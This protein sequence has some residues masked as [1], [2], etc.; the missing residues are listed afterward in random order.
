M[1]QA[2]DQ[3]KI[4]VITKEDREKFKRLDHYLDSNCPEI[5]RSLLKK[6]FTH[7]NAITGLLTTTPIKL[8]L[9]KMP[10][11]NTQVTIQIPE[12]KDSPLKAENIPLEI[13]FEDEHLVFINKPAGLVTHPAPGNETGTLVQAILHHCPKLEGM[14]DSKRPGIVH[15]L[16]KGTTGVMVVAKNQK[17]L[18]GL[19]HI[20]ANH[21]IQRIYEAITLGPDIP[22]GGTLK[23]TLGRHPQ[24]RLKMAV[25]PLRGGKIA[26][27]HFKKLK[28]KNRLHHLELKLETG[29]THQIRVHLTSLLKHPI[30]G[31]SVYTA[32][33]GQM[34]QLND[35]LKEALHNYSHPLLHARDLGLIHPITKQNLY[36]KAPY[37][38]MFKKVLAIFEENRI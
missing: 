38:E 37:P 12:Q 13:L 21:N 26:I 16:D 30:V 6:L 20:F 18:E 25:N 9:K 4:F 17:T 11:E 23:S 2:N 5:S 34:G 29:R 1:T 14:M 15:R 35:V 22:V 3:K 7:E 28:Q 24:N 19:G 27:T 32:R 36:I 31:D 33:Q 8:E 10:P